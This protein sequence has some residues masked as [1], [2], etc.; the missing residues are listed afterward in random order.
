VEKASELFERWSIKFSAEFYEAR[1]K[2][3]A[4]KRQTSA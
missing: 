3:E 2:E 1:E 4:A